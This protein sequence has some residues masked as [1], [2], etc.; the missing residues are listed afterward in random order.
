MTLLKRTGIV[1]GVMA[2]LL[3]LGLIFFRSVVNPAVMNEIRTH[4]NGEEAKVA[5]I[6]A[7]DDRTL[8]VNYLKEDNLVF[9][10]VDGPWWRDFRGEKKPVSMMI[11]GE[12]LTG[13]GVVVLDDDDYVV[14]VLSRLRP[15]APDWLPLW[16]NGKLV[17][18]T[19]SET[20]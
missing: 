11:K 20:G 15:T 4:P 13:H 18:I 6:I 3:I 17:V 1:I 5:M 9:I 10:A 14:D 16:L 7:Y 19:L 2:V 12:T 8:P